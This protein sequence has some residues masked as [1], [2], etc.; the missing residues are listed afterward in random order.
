MGVSH[1]SWPSGRM[2]HT[3]GGFAFFGGR[4]MRLPVPLPRPHVPA[5]ILAFMVLINLARRSGDQ[6]SPGY[7]I[8]LGSFAR[9][10]LSISWRRRFLVAINFL[11]CSGVHALFGCRSSLR[12]FA[13]D[14]F[15]FT[16]N[17]R[18][19]RSASRFFRLAHS[20]L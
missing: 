11:R 18:F 17:E 14:F 4:P 15:G 3:S 2:P 5:F 19:L 8:V 16:L 1:P 20:A 12:G 13:L 10:G 6:A 9:D 7:F